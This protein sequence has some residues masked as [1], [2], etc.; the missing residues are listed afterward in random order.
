M[1]RVS[2]ISCWI[3]SQVNCGTD[4]LGIAFQCRTCRNLRPGVPPPVPEVSNGDE[5]KQ[6]HPRRFVSSKIQLWDCSM[7]SAKNIPG[8]TQC[9]NC[10][11]QIRVLSPKS[12]MPLWEVT[13]T[14]NT[15]LEVDQLVS[16]K[17][18]MCEACNFVNFRQRG[19]CLVCGSGRLNIPTQFSRKNDQKLATKT[20]E[21]ETW[22]C[23]NCGQGDLNGSFLSCPACR[24]LRKG[25]W[26]CS[27][28]KDV[29]FPTSKWCRKCLKVH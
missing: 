15:S 13:F 25:V 5:S 23:G 6:I 12:T 22:D 9:Y 4:N 21:E 2:R 10:G 14:H 24:A 1:I 28:C 8:E 19:K 29:N 27:M 18:W 16:S 20:S 3:C 26:E 7:C 17:D 11:H